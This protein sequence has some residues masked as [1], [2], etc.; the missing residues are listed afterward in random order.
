MIEKAVDLILLVLLYAP[1]AA[2]MTFIT[3]TYLAYNCEK[4][5]RGEEQKYRAFGKPSSPYGFFMKIFF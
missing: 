4:D 2:P 1:Y 3:W 5:L